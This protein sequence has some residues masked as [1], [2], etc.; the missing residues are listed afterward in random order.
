MLDRLAVRLSGA[1]FGNTTS[2]RSQAYCV[3]KKGS[4][5]KGCVVEGPQSHMAQ[6]LERL[7]ASGSDY[8]PYLQP[9][10]SCG[11]AYYNPRHAWIGSHE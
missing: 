10:L 3:E 1:S 7:H 5:I 6:G 8:T 2:S 11:F 4:K 9:A